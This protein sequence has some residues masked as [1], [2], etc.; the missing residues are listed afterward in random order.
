MKAQAKEASIL[1]VRMADVD[2][3][4]FRRLDDY[5]FVERKIEALIQSYKD[6]GMW[7]G[8][9][10]RK[11]GNRVQIA[12]GHHRWEAA[13]RTNMPSIKIIIQD[14]SDEKMLAYMGRENLE[15]YNADFLCMLETWEAG[16]RFLSL[17]AGEKVQPLEIAH[18][19]GWVRPH[20]TGT[21]QLNNT[22]DACRTAYALI[23]AGH[24]S[25]YDLIDMS[26]KAAG[27]IT[28]RAVSRMEFLDKAAKAGGRPKAEVE[29]DKK[30]VAR[31]VKQTAHEAREGNVAIKKVAQRVD[32]NTYT[33]MKEEKRESPLFGV[34][35]KAMNDQIRSMLATDNVAAKLRDI[36]DAVEGG[37]ISLEADH[38]SIRYTDFELGNLMTRANRGSGRSPPS[39]RN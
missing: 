13:R 7:P 36:V 28:Q 26:V 33:R 4:P 20:K 5:P 22:A 29:K 18:L 10:G 38:E 12:F 14:L 21:M 15:D 34:F 17:R 39:R 25:R 1:D 2:A 8:I 19:L 31:A 30:F 32:E 9:I 37:K 16:A 24:I 11:V 27:E 35:A 6:V 3:N 23:K